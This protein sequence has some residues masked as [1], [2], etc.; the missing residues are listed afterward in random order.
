MAVRVGGNLALRCPASA[1]DHGQLPSWPPLRLQVEAGGSVKNGAL[2]HHPQRGILAQTLQ[3]V[4]RS[5]VNSLDSG[6]KKR[7][8]RGGRISPG[9][10]LPCLVTPHS[11][12]HRR[13]G[14]PPPPP[15]PHHWP[16][17]P[18]EPSMITMRHLKSTFPAVP[19]SRPFL[20]CKFPRQQPAGQL[21]ITF[22]AETVAI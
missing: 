9:S 21:K 15:A 7:G 4:E 14:V 3:G 6:S 1:P 11:M 12:G 16:R 17:F 22:L 18:T 2:S 5:K 19:L 8:W 10:P 13:A 20:V